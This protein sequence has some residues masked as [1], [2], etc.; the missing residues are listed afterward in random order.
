MTL[1][2]HCVHLFH[3]LIN[4]DISISNLIFFES[5]KSINRWRGKGDD[6]KIIILNKCLIRLMNI[7]YSENFQKSF[8]LMFDIFQFLDLYHNI[9]CFLSFL[10]IKF[11]LLLISFLT[12]ILISLNYFKHII[13]H[14]KLEILNVTPEIQWKK[15]D[16]ENKNIKNYVENVLVDQTLQVRTFIEIPVL[17]N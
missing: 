1:N 12:L 15:D 2:L 16:E 6:T 3:Y 11:L 4:E 14:D 8:I 13:L 9:F 5:W 7:S 17:Y 10:L